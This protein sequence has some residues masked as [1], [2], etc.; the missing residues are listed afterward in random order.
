MTLKVVA[1][2]SSGASTLHCWNLPLA[3]NLQTYGSVLT[4]DKGAP[5]RSN[6]ALALE[7][8][9]EALML[10]TALSSDGETDATPAVAA[11]EAAE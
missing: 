6:I 7:V 11:D 3:L 9:G 10:A 4:S 8:A 2:M 5:S 1:T